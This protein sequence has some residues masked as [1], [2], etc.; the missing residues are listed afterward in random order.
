[1]QELGSIFAS[2]GL[3]EQTVYAYKKCGEV[4]AALD[5]CIQLNNWETAVALAKT[6]HIPV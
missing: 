5:T 1:M 3:C 6:H 4:R 2:A